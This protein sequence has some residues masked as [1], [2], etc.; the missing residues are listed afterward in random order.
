MTSFTDS[1]KHYEVTPEHCTCPDF[2]YRQSKTGGKCKHQKMLIAEANRAM[3]FLL[4]MARFDIRSQAVI[5]AKRAAYWNY[6]MA[7]QAA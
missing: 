6:E 5:E 3:H 2:Q 7:I 1:N 4:L